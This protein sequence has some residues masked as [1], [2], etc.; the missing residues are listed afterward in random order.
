[1]KGQDATS[2]TKHDR[3]SIHAVELLKACTHSDL[4]GRYFC[5]C[6]S[7]FKYTRHERAQSTTNV[8][9]QCRELMGWDYSYVENTSKN[10]VQQ[11]MRQ[12]PLSP[13]SPIAFWL[14]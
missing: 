8:K 7:F 4:E 9:S 10:Q 6:S 12:N 2:T 14:P 3:A 11:Y 5:I 1:M 13:I